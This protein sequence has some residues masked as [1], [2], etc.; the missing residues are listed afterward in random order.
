MKSMALSG[1]RPLF[2][3]IAILGTA[4]AA[5][6]ANIIG[7]LYGFSTGLPHLLYIPVVIAAYQYPRRGAVI[8]GCIAGIY[9]LF[10]IL[11]AGSSTTILAEALLRTLVIIVIGW[12]IATLALRLREKETLYTGLFDHSEGGSILISDLSG[13]RTIEEI[14]WRAADLLR[15]NTAELK[16][17]PVTSFWSGKD[18]VDFFGRLIA[19]KAVYD[20]ETTFALPDDDSLI[21]VVS[22]AGIPGGRAIITF[23]DIT[24]RVH[25]EKALKTANDKLSLL[26]QYS[27]DHLHASV[28]Q[29]IETIEEADTHT[30]DAATHGYL[31]R[32]RVLAWN[33]VR[34]LFLTESYKDLGA[35]PPVWMSVQQSLE[36]ALLPSDDGSVSIRCWAGRLEI[37]A[38]PLFSD[39]FTHLLE[40]SLRHGG[41]KVKN[42]VITCH[43]TPDG[44]FLCIKDDGVGIPAGKKHQVFEYDAGKHAGIG[45]FICRQIVEVT[46]MT[47]QE[48][49]TG[50]V[51]A[52]FV[53]HVPPGGYRIEGATEDAPPLPP[54]S[55][56]ARF[57]LKHRTGVTVRELLSGEFSLAETLWTDYHAT[58]GDRR[59]DRIFAA[60]SGGKVVSVARCRRHVDGLEVDGVFTPV[61]QRGHG[62]ANAV[63]LGLVEACGEEDPLYM[64][65]VRDLTK[66]YGNFGFVP[67]DEKELPPSIRE[68]FAWAQGE[69][70]GAN[71]MPMKREPAP[72]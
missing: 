22:A 40:N 33:V 4:V 34:Q 64:H 32:I 24:S 37:Y 39:V 29:I 21:V 3:N 30:K 59:T 15:R 66:F 8:S 46:G 6:L 47:I 12:L 17:S 58:K 2:W 60:F 20:A 42:I 16:G 1:S 19:E 62:Y 61:S 43:E 48:T 10:V 49:G 53:I 50:G 36:T 28:D 9:L 67:I 56:P 14:N 68:R 44:L 31:E 23:F 27:V 51:G 13:S 69:M 26:S 55:E 25:A 41:A 38:D 45:L 63:V 52:R 5:L 65:S 7:L 70:E 18:Q 11:L 35:L 72:V 54:S 57:V 71:V